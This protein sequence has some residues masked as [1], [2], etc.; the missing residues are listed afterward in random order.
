[1]AR[2][3]GRG[4]GRGA[5][6]NVAP[7]DEVGLMGRIAAEDMGSFETLYR[8]YH[9]RLMRFLAGM[10]RRPALAEEILDD[11]MLV[12]WRKAHTYY[13]N[14]KVSTWIFAI[15]Y[16]QALQALRKVDDAVEAEAEPHTE[17]M[18]AGPDI[19]LQQHEVRARL[20]QALMALSA[21]QRAV[22]ELTYYLGY[23]CREIAQ[24]MDCP[25]DTVKTRMFYARRRLKTLLGTNLEEA[26]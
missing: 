12:V 22:I 20:V 6:D 3:S 23:A 1:M 9:P 19:E 4:D 2:P 15:A 8:L 18:Q 13:P 10:T 16:R 14:A 21:E 5:T 11:T 25:V 7:V 24:I 26:I 17:S